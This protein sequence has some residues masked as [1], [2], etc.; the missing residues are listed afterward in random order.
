MEKV[1]KKVIHCEKA[2]N[3]LLN[4]GIYPSKKGYMYLLAC[5][6][7]FRE[8]TNPIT[9]IYKRVAEQFGVKSTC[10]ERCMRFALS[11]A[12]FLRSFMHLNDCFN[13]NVMKRDTY[14]SNGSFIS[15]VALYLDMIDAPRMIVVPYNYSEKN[16]I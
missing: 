13:T 16:R 15:M 9:T 3:I 8:T 14:L 10:V 4:L 5:I 12:Y 7:E 11:E 6:Q 1:K 2:Q